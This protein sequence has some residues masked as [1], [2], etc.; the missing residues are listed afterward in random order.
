MAHPAHPTPLFFHE[1]RPRIPGEN[2]PDG[3]CYSST[4]PCAVRASIATFSSH[5]INNNRMLFAQSARRPYH[6]FSHVTSTLFGENE[7]VTR[8]ELP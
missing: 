2:T 3:E 6:N 4:P 8:S 7:F 5:D 1:L